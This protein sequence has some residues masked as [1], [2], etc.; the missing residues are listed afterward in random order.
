VI[1]G[2]FLAGEREAWPIAL[3]Q[4]DFDGIGKGAGQQRGIGSFGRR[5]GAGTCRPPPAQGPA[6]LF[7][8]VDILNGRVSI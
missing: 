1:A 7:S 6:R 3:G 2:Q 4:G 8:H 5:G